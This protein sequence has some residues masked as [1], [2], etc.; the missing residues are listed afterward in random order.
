MHPF[1]EVIHVEVDVG[2]QIDLIDHQGIDVFVHAGVFIGFVIPLGDRS[3]E[4]ILMRA[5]FEVCRADQV[6]DVFDQQ[7]VE[8]REFELLEGIAQHDRV[9]VALTTGV[10]LDGRGPGGSGPVGV[11]AGGDIAIYGGNLETLSY[12]LERLFDERGFASAWGGHQ[13]DAEDASLI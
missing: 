2:K 3:D 4:Y 1:A 10:D 7:Q 6:A 9:E 5:Q 8:F 12:S 11:D 13:V